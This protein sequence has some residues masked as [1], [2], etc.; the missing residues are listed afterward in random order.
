MAEHDNNIGA[1]RTKLTLK[2]LRVLTRYR[3]YEMK[4]VAEDLAIST[5]PKLLAMTSCLGWCGKAVDGLVDRLSFREF[6]ND[7]LG[8][9]EIFQRNN[10]DILTDSASLSALIAS[11]SFAYISR[12][13]SKFPRIQIIDASNA[14][15]TIDPI[16][17]LL[18]E[19]YAVLKRSESLSV[20]E[21][22]YFTGDYTAYL[23]NGQEYRRDPNPTGYPLLVPI[24]YRPDAVR[25]FG[26]SRITRACMSIVDAA[27]RTVKRCE[28]S[29]EFYS[30]P[31]KYVVGLSNDSEDVDSWKAAM[32]AMLSFTKDEEGDSP[33]VGQ[34]TQQSMQPHIDQIRM[35]ASLFAGETGLT[36]DDMG[37]PSDNPSSSE[38]IK[39]SHETMRLSARKAQR[40]IGT[41]LLNTG[42]VAACLRDEKPYSRDKI[43][44]IKPIWEPA[45]EKDLSAMSMAGDAVIKINQAVPGF[46]TI[47]NLRDITGVEHGGEA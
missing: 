33:K 46:F 19:G 15:G 12:G 20:V 38:S 42:F 43:H 18:T 27:M 30:F 7:E 9:N 4:H 29:A 25:P 2:S 40:C 31:Q 23:K 36:L 8:M 13:E 39:A 6:R 21:E 17:G 41:G 11:C 16:T 45:F 35:L 14:T 34:F 32:S 5:P 26:H 10:P 3:F 24:I 28:I 1:L 22:A 37:F 47:E 44:M